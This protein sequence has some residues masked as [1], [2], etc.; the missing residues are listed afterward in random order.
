MVQQL[1]RQ[2]RPDGVYF[3][4]SSAYHRYT[5]DFYTHL[6]ILLRKSASTAESDLATIEDK[7]KALLDHLM[8]ITRPDGT[9]PLFGDDDGGRLLSFDSRA[10]N[11]FRATLSTGAVLFARGDYKFVAG[12]LAE[13][14]FWLLGPE[15]ARIFESVEAEKPSLQSKDFPDGGYFVMRDGWD[16]KA[17]YLL[18]DCGPHGT[19]NCGHA[20]ADA[21]AIEVAAYGQPTLIDPGTYTYTGSKEERDHFRSSGSHNVL[22][23]DG[24]PSSLPDGPFSW[25]T[26]ARCEP[27]SWI[28]ERRFDLSPAG[29][30]ATSDWKTGDA[31]SQHSVSEERLLAN[32][33]PFVC[34]RRPRLGAPISLCPWARTA[35]RT[36]PA[37]RKSRDLW[38]ESGGNRR[39][40]GI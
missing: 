18:F 20:H 24:E 19:S 28:N 22:L 21:L 16:E 2:V 33:R 29:M 37:T 25:K 9:T 40:T 32:A 39:F 27:L 38:G 23:V 4:Q 13:E 10:A 35:T 15:G 1:A 7:L 31:H 12:E 8:Y 36:H 6:L 26:I 17:N 30:M 14:T 11:D 5:A 34:K 3:E